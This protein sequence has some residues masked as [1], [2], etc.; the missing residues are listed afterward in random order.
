M[1]MRQPVPTIV[2]VEDSPT[3]EAL[4]LR[5]FKRNGISNPVV[6]LRD[7]IQAVE[8]FLGTSGAGWRPGDPH[9]VL[10][11]LKLPRLNGFQ[12]LK[13]LR[14]DERTRTLP[15]IV[16]TSSDEQRD[17]V[18]AYRLGVNS[19]IRKPVDFAEFAETVKTIGHY[20]VI[21]NL[22]PRPPFR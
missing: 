18:E 5:A 2:L 12:V 3:D 8:Y 16:L 20:W 10:L 15:V 1:T 22:V 14:G 17:L 11:D 19:Y 6:V 7:G 13:R 21:L 9:V 4:A